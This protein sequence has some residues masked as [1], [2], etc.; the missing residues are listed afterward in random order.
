MSFRHAD[1]TH[2]AENAG[3]REIC[4]GAHV[5]EMGGKSFFPDEHCEHIISSEVS[6]VRNVE[7]ERREA[8]LVGTDAFAIEP[9]F[10]SAVHTVEN[11]FDSTST[12]T[13]GD[14]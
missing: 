1:E 12:K 11:Q 6:G 10:G 14:L 5:V 9:D 8:A 2:R 4:V 3:E 7:F 13:R